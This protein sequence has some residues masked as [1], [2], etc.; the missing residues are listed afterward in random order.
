V[1]AAPDDLFDAT[2]D[3]LWRRVLRRQPEPLS[4]LATYPADPTQN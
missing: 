2:P 1:A 3:G 4:W